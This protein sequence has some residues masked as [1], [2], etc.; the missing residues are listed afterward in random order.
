MVA[1]AIDNSRGKE[2]DR[3]ITRTDVES[4]FELHMLPMGRVAAALGKR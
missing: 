3:N 2:V 1:D 4:E